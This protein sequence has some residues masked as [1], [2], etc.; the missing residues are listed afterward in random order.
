MK[1]AVLLYRYSKLAEM[2]PLTRFLYILLFTLNIQANKNKKNSTTELKNLFQYKNHF[3]I[4]I[5]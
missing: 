1:D 3:C 5:Q 2:Y 4:I